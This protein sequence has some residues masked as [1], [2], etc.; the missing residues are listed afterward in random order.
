VAVHCLLLLHSAGII[1]RQKRKTL[2]EHNDF[3]TLKVFAKKV[4]VQT[5]EPVNF[6]SLTKKVPLWT[7]EPA[8]HNFAW[9]PLH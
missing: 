7:M 9:V 6:K 1:C 4:P 8:Y 2:A 5:M 3:A